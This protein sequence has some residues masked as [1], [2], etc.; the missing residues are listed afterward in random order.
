MTTT[1]RMPVCHC[2]ACG[3][4]LD[5]ATHPG[6]DAPSPGD[7]SICLTCG[8]IMMF[9]DDLTLR[10][11]TDAEMIMLAG[12]RE[13]VAAQKARQMSKLPSRLRTRPRDRRGYVIPWV[14]FVADDG[15]PNFAVLEEGK[16]RD[17][18]R[19]RLC[20]LCG[21]PMGRHV[22][23][24]GGPLTVANR[25]FYDPPMHKECAIYALETCP[26]LARSKGRYRDPAAVKEAIKGEAATLVVGEMVTATKCDYYALMHAVSYNHGRTEQGMLVVRA[27][28]WIDVEYWKDGKAIG[29]VPP[30]SESADESSP[31]L[32]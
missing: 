23:F 31:R 11:P 5:C 29:P 4:E 24:V 30:V 20:G 21:Q 6:I 12:D 2:L 17:A 3:A 8:H 14:Q 26:H 32:D 27:G 28:P 15:T 16:T 7:V 25:Y 9:A 10:N 1:T 18:L 13:I 22:Y 19:R